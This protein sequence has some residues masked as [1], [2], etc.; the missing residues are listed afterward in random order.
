[1][2]ICFER[3]RRE[4]QAAAIL[5]H[6]NICPIYD[7]GEIDGIHHISM[8]FIEGS[9]LSSYVNADD[10]I[11]IRR[12][13]LIVRKVAS[14]IAEAHRHEI[15]HRDL[16][17]ANIM[18]DGKG[19][20]IVMDFGLARI[21]Q[22]QGEQLTQEGMAMGSPA[23]MSP[24][25]FEGKS[26]N[27]GASCDTY[28]LGVV[29]YELLTG[30]IPF[31]G[32]MLQIMAQV[33]KECTKRPS[34]LRPEIDERLDAI[35]MKMMHREAGSRH[36]SMKAVVASLTKYLKSETQKA[37]TPKPTPEPAPAE[38]DE[39]ENPEP[40]RPSRRRRKKSGIR[41]G[42]KKVSSGMLAAGGG[43]LAVLLTGILWVVF[44]GDSGPP[45]PPVDSLTADGSD[46]ESTIA[47]GVAANPDV[48][49]NERV[50]PNLDD[51]I[52]L[53]NFE[54]DSYFDGN[55]KQLIRDLSGLNNHGEMHGPATTEHGRARA[56]LLFDGRDD[57]IQLPGIADDLIEDTTELTLALWFQPGDANRSNFQLDVCSR[58]GKIGA[59]R[60]I[61]ETSK[62]LRFRPRN[63]ELS[64]TVDMGSRW[65]HI[66]ATWRGEQRR[67]FLDGTVVGERL[68]SAMPIAGPLP[69][70]VS[71]IGGQAHSQT[72]R[73]PKGENRALSGTLDEYILLRRA[74]SEEE[75]GQLYQL[76]VDG[77]SLTG[78]AAP[79]SPQP[80]IVE[81]VPLKPGDRSV[82]ACEELSTNAAPLGLH[83]DAA[84][85]AS[86]ASE[87][88]GFQFLLPD[89][90]AWS[91]NEWQFDL[92]LGG[93]K[94]RAFYLTQP[95]RFGHFTLLMT[96]DACNLYSFTEFPQRGPTPHS[97][98]KF[99]EFEH[100]FPLDLDQTYRIASRIDEVGEYLLTIDGQPILK[101]SFPPIREYI[102]DGRTI[103]GLPRGPVRPLIYRTASN[104]AGDRLVMKWPV[105]TGELVIDGGGGS[106]GNVA[107][108]IRVIQRTPDEPRPVSDGQ[109]LNGLVAWYR[110]DESQGR[111]VM[112]SSGN[113]HDGTAS[114]DL[115][116]VPGVSGGAI[117]IDVETEI[118]IGDIANLEWNEPFT[119]CAWVSP[120]AVEGSIIRKRNAVNRGYNLM[121]GRSSLGWGAV[122]TG[123]NMLGIYAGAGAI[124]RKHWS[125][126]AVAYDGTG[127]RLSPVTYIDGRQV[128][129]N[130]TS[131]T[132][133][134]TM[135]V[136]DPL[137]IGRGY[138][139]KLD[140][141]RVYNRMLTNEEITF[142]AAPDSSELR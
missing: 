8:A 103:S 99:P 87:Q 117:E 9:P 128:K 5:R 72:L 71:R 122:H 26:E 57:Y 66:A 94:G 52:L 70:L 51:A 80:I 91:A 102:V 133:S 90:K 123:S 1:M 58:D 127:R 62:R 86:T 29:L 118:S 64:A 139:G 78:N 129:Y 37:V 130:N 42:G 116:Q 142:L 14:A 56:G 2:R 74:M 60:L 100:F 111:D 53:F 65:H 50:V 16:K 23:Y 41:I 105:G 113:G 39:W 19:E 27:M 79:E 30:T 48:Q 49:P 45:T 96:R 38:A 31:R 21:E 61:S 10:P 141:I 44:G 63:D 40:R 13:V 15:I 55:G 81:N 36:G 20:P 110:F 67:V 136:P 35:C 12:A 73:G 18:M 43:T 82:V 92:R 112:D 95:F 32:S 134:A 28:S 114:A 59:L 7:V 75:I 88:K 89:W 108:G 3:F 68:G 137:V 6:P 135:R 120:E 93:T 104:Y 124:V 138:A 125:H 115:L 126:V 69:P 17:P 140:D 106:Q 47:V 83:A 107:S 109:L 77:V 85:Y 98:E 101:A 24:E 11:Q 97:T 46:G 34:Q 121:F 131:G 22:P 132:L 33:L 54:P 76:G 25:Q 4:A 119:L 84:P